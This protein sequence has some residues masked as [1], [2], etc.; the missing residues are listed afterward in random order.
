MSGSSDYTQTPNL[1]LYKPISNRAIGTWGDLWNSNADTLDATMAHAQARA[2]DVANVL[3]YGA[4]PGNGIDSTAAFNLAASQTNA[5][6][7][8]KAVYVPTGSYRIDGQINLTGGQA[9]YGDSRGTSVLIVSQTFSPSATSVIY[10]TSGGIDPGPTIRDLGITFVQ[11]PDQGSRAN[12]KTLAAGGTA[13][14][15]GSGIKYP[16]AISAGSD[17]F[18][19]QVIRVRIG[20]A[21]DGI[22]TNNHNAVYWLTDVEIGALD[23]GVSLGEGT[24]VLDFAHISGFHF[25]NFDLGA[26]L[27]N[28][29][30]DGQTIAMRLGGQNGLDARGVGS[31]CGQIIFTPEASNGWFSF[32]NL[33]LDGDP[34]TMQIYACQWIN[35]SNMYS[36]SSP[37]GRGR[38][39]VTVSGGISTTITNWFGSNQ[40]PYQH[41]YV[42]GGDVTL[43]NSYFMAL[44]ATASVALVNSGTLRLLG[45]KVN[46]GMASAYTQPLIAQGGSGILQVTDIDATGATSGSSGRVVVFGTDNVGNMLGDVAVSSGWKNGYPFGNN[47][48][49]GDVMV[50]PSDSSSIQSGS[51]SFGQFTTSGHNS[52]SFGANALASHQNAGQQNT[53][54]GALAGYGVTTGGFNAF[55]GAASGYAPSGITGNNNACFGANTAYNLT[56]GANNTLLGNGAGYVLTTGSGNILLGDGSGV[57]AASATESNTFRVGTSSVT[58]MRG[59]ALNTS[60]PHL[61]LDWLPASTTY[62]S[63]AAASA[64]GVAVGQ[65]YRNGSAVMCRIT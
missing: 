25:W 45:C 15:G 11:P 41:L 59:T 31:F 4:D 1:L 51:T 16:W 18:R 35:I 17:S 52:T 58:L 14:A 30:N 10:C 44:N 43:T 36:S 63:D 32:T 8:H 62:A 7:R 27:W 21:W 46:V 65:L 24:P 60:A 39:R 6:G 53:A 13:G 64:G 54:V 28:V 57:Q 48:Y 33:G 2:A 47:G 26:S 50:S 12:F 61:F 22:T 38:P 42:N 3:D 34:A 29:Y 56:S 40:S 5:S 55:F 9:L 23:C 49:Y 20:G 37:D 19:I